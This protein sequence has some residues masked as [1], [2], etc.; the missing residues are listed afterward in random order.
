MDWVY[1]NDGRKSLPCLIRDVA[2]EGAGIMIAD[3]PQFRVR[4]ICPFR[5]GREGWVLSQASARLLLVA[6][7]LYST[8]LRRRRAAGEGI[9]NVRLFVLFKTRPPTAVIVSCPL[10]EHRRPGPTRSHVS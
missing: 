6:A 2:Y 9:S 3:P 1:F 4:S 7:R 10:Y 5:T 8:V